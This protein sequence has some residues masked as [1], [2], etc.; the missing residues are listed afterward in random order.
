MGLVKFNPDPVIKSAFKISKL[1]K[2]L[3]DNQDP[4]V[5]EHIRK[6]SGILAQ[7]AMALWLVL[8]FEE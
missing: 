2:L 7:R 8:N 4:D 6:E 3:Q 5:F 1:T